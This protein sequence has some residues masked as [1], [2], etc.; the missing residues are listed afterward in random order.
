M[1]RLQLRFA[2]TLE[3]IEVQRESDEAE[4]LNYLRKCEKYKVIGDRSGRP[5]GEGLR[6]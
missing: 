6:S 3:E 5:D 4:L 1:R 2:D